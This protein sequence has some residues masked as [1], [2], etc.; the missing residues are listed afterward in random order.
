M[1]LLTDPSHLIFSMRKQM[2]AMDDPLLGRVV[3]IPQKSENDYILTEHLAANLASNDANMRSSLFRPRERR[4]RE[5]GIAVLAGMLSVSSGTKAVS[6]DIPSGVSESVDLFPLSSA[7]STA[8]ANVSA[9]P[10]Y[11]DASSANSDLSDG[12]MWTSDSA[13]VSE[14]RFSWAV[15]PNA[16]GMNPG[17]GAGAGGPIELVF[18]PRGGF[19]DRRAAG[20]GQNVQRPYRFSGIRKTVSLAER[21]NYAVHAGTPPVVVR[22][23]SIRRK[24]DSATENSKKNGDEAE[25]KTESFKMENNGNSL[26]KERVSFAVPEG[27]TAAASLF[28]RTAPSAT[29][30]AKKSALAFLLNDQ[31]ATENPFAE[32]FGILSGK[33]EAYPIR[34]KIYVPTS[35][36]P[37]EPML[38]IVKRS[39]SVE[40]LI[41]YTLYEYFNK[42]S[43]ESPDALET[44]L[45]QDKCD[46][47]CWNLR[48]V[49]DDGTIDDD[50]PALDR[51]SKMQ[52]SNFDALALSLCT[53][54]QVAVNQAA[55]NARPSVSKSKPA[56]QS[57][58]SG[59]TPA[60]TT[61]PTSP[62]SGAMPFSVNAPPSFGVPMGITTSN[63]SAFGNTTSLPRGPN[64][65]PLPPLPPGTGGT[66]ATN[67]GMHNS[68]PNNGMSNSAGNMSG[69]P[70]AR[71]QI[72]IKIHLYSTLEVKQTTTFAFQGSATMGEVFE[73]I[74]TRR[75]YDTENYVLKMADTKTDVALDRILEDM[76]STEF[77]VLK[78]D[79][80]G[81]GDIFLRP[82]GETAAS[83]GNESHEFTPEEIACI[84]RQY[85]VTQKQLIGRNERIITL[86]GEYVHIMSVGDS[87]AIVNATATFHISAVVSCLLLKKQSRHLKFTVAKSPGSQGTA[88][89]TSF[90]FEAASEMQATDICMRIASMIQLHA[91]N[92]GSNSVNL[93]SGVLDAV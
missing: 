24:Q 67:S 46:V 58:L 40:E 60:A 81:A 6:N 92:G 47:S 42:I 31:G 25:P 54:S 32:E 86:D 83:T 4:R 63:H 65:P 93:T 69:G 53:P 39:A 23:S 49:E 91:G 52:R 59:G 9:D 13:R 16:N 43:N 90:E 10:R 64:G 22:D 8:N 11:S 17:N 50:F 44:L 18:Q 3:S 68:A 89:A 30:A 62:R 19:F 34:I 82:P 72:F 29:P 5:R 37:E 38:I 15:G 78:K 14:A 87:K 48:L 61:G 12:L 41:G 28:A 33:G 76:H 35:L 26:V 7:I 51:M 77:C 75:K 2:L 88:I 70:P 36:K 1:A 57:T 45:P 21:P 27:A 20:D 74:C 56:L 66:Q 73:T 71:P 80:G 79:R 85:S 55:R 84:Y